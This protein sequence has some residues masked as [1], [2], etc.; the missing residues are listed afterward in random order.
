MTEQEK[1]LQELRS[2]LDHIFFNRFIEAKKMFKKNPD[3]F[4]HLMGLAGLRTAVAAMTLDKSRISVAMATAWT[5]VK[6]SDE[7]RKSSGMIFRSDPNDYTDDECH[8]E[9]TH[10]ELQAIY[11]CLCAIDNQGLTGFMKG[12]FRVRSCFVGLKECERLMNGKTN[13]QSELLRQE[14]CSGVMLDLGLFEMG[15]SFVPRKFQILLELLGF[16]SSRTFGLDKLELASKYTLSLR[17]IAAMVALF[18]YHMFAEYFYGLGEAKRD[19]LLDC[20]QFADEIIPSD[21]PYADLVEG[22]LHNVEARYAS[23]LTHYDAI[24]RQ[25]TTPR[26]MVYGILCQQAWISTILCDW[27]KAL[28]CSRILRQECKWSRSLFA[29]MYAIYASLVLKQSKGPA[30]EDAMMESLADVPRVKRHFGGKKAFHEK[31]VIEKAA[32]YLD[33]PEKMV[34]PHLDLMYLWNLFVQASL[35][36]PAL[37]KIKHLIEEELSH[38]SQDKDVDLFCYLTFMR[39]CVYAVSRYDAIAVDCF[40]HVIASQEFIIRDTHL[41]PQACFEMGMLYR[42]AGDVEESKKWFQKTKKFSDYLT[43]SMIS[44]RMECAMQSLE[45]ADHK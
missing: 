43:E 16:P 31:I 39:G 24:L 38:V 14:F 32:V 2:S 11:G 6:K 26:G 30:L 12:A 33:H 42:R 36:A 34:L 10:S 9:L 8:A 4:Y 44:F 29:F 25:P 40:L 18:G 20:V 35:D 13:W 45:D 5:A 23:A 15:L 27:E 17:R 1:I 7:S 21:S 37:K 28:E 19:I 22:A 3:S 41:V